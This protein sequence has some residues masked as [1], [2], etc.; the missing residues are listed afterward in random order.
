MNTLR[1]WLK[2]QNFQRGLNHAMQ[3]S[4]LCDAESWA[5]ATGT[6]RQ[7]GGKGRSKGK[8]KTLSKLTAKIKQRISYSIC[9]KNI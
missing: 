8:R 9:S 4:K 2:L 5:G 1:S 7:T 6:H 3:S